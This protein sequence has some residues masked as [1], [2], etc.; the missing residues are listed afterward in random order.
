MGE[1]RRKERRND[2]NLV[3]IYEILKKLK[4]IFL[5]ESYFIYN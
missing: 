5:K 4:K 1:F 2:G 3:L